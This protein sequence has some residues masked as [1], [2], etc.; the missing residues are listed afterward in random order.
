MRSHCVLSQAWYRRASAR[1]GLGDVQGCLGDCE[2]ALQLAN[3]PGAEAGAGAGVKEIQVGLHGLCI[4]HTPIYTYTG[5]YIHII[6]MYP[7]GP[8]HSPV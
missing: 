5:I 3:G 6:Y 8:P 2:A 1:L 7:S 4:R